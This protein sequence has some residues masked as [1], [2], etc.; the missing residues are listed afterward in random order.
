MRA[1]RRAAGC[2]VVLAGLAL[3]VPAGSVHPTTISLTRTQA[4][5]GVDAGFDDD[6]LWVLALGSDAKGGVD[7]MDGRTDAIQL[8]GI[9][10]RSGR[11]T[12][13]GVPRDL[14]V[15]F[16]TEDARINE[17][18]VTPEGGV[19]LAAREV[20]DII[21]IAPDLVL[22]T[23]FE[24][25]RS[26]IGAIGGVEVDS[27][28]AFTTRRLGVSV[29]KG[30]NFFNPAQA[31]DYARTRIGV[32]GG[33]R[34]RSANHQR[35]LLGVLHGLVKDEDGQ[36]FMERAAVAAVSGLETDLTPTEIYRLVQA[37][38]TVDPSQVTHCV[39]IGEDYT[40]PESG[41]QVVINYEKQA[42][43]LGADAADDMRLPRHCHAGET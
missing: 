11:A 25:F 13:I 26:M 35:L 30:P 38:T 27:D 20:E 18:L 7:V 42:R 40:F 9:D 24:G 4:A 32:T 36:G 14:W 21:G 22:V 2:L 29:T 33:D 23:G 16:P 8:I 12:A 6:T 34:G 31:L 41:G 37:V 17:V 1:L 43:A 10:W 5:G 28:E 3:V 39:I 19:D 15:E